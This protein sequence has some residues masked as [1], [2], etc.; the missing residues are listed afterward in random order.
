[1]S[2]KKKQ[3]SASSKKQRGQENIAVRSNTQKKDPYQEALKMLE[4]Y[5][6]GCE[7]PTSFSAVDECCATASH[8]ACRE[9]SRKENSKKRKE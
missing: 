5:D 3:Q 1:M 4:A 7:K 2:S 9:S 8:N 6:E